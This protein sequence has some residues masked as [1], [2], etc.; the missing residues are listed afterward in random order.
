MK[1]VSCIWY[2]NIDGGICGPLH[3]PDGRFLVLCDRC[4]GCG[5]DPKLTSAELKTASEDH[6]LSPS[7]ERQA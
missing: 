2:V 4:A 6:G 7:T 3:S 5:Y 1:D